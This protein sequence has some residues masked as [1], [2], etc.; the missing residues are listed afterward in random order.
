M[1]A[2]AARAEL[3][4]RLVAQ[5]LRHRRNAPVFVHHVVLAA[6]LELAAHAEARLALDDVRETIPLSGDRVR[7]AVEDGQLHAARDVHADGVR[8]HRVVR[9]EH[10]ADRQAV[11]DV[12]IRHERARHR[13]R[14][15]TRI[16]HLLHRLR[17]EALAPLT[18]RRERLALRERRLV[19]R[20]SK[21]LAQRIAEK[22]DRI[23][24]NCRHLVFEARGIAAPANEIDDELERELDRRAVRHAE[25][26]EVFGVHDCTT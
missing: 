12:R 20:A 8:N 15:R 18:P 19:E 24:D 10:A 4:P 11:A 5:P 3:R 9:R 14:Q 17:L 13:D 23:R 26:D 6:L 2:A 21:R 7:L 22:R 25:A 16:R 1:I